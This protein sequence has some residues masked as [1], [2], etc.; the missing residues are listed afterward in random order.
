MRA[1]AC[2]RASPT[3]PCASACRAP[4]V[5][6]WQYGTPHA[7][8]PP[9]RLPPTT[10]SESA[11]VRRANSAN[12]RSVGKSSA[13]QPEP[14]AVSSC[15]SSVLRPLPGLQPTLPTTAAQLHAGL[16]K[17][18]ASRAAT[19]L[20]ASTALSNGTIST[21]GGF[22]APISNP[23]RSSSSITAICRDVSPKLSTPSRREK[24]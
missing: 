1:L 12:A 18:H 16:P 4:G 24:L 6:S 2:Q 10:L 8:E 13:C 19:R 22:N 3:P 9:L 11:S 17:A 7:P 21:G 23:S 5:G 15:S 14:Q 20:Y